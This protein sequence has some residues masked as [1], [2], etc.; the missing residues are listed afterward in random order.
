[1]RVE[2][3]NAERSP[4]L[5]IMSNA[6]RAALDD[7]PLTQSV[8]RQRPSNLPILLVEDEPDQARLVQDVLKE[9]SSLTLLP[10]MPR[11][12][13][14]IAYLS[15]EGRYGDRA[16]YP[17]PF[18]MLL[19]LKMPG[20]GGFGVLRWLQT[21]PEVNGNL[22]TVVLSS[23][24]SSEELELAGGLGAKEYWVKS[25]WMLLALRIRDLSASLR[26]EA[27]W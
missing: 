20:I 2:K 25:D 13:E 7:L 1:M 16:A 26:D 24:Q 18:L 12:E 5:R 10:V 21:H 27:R 4:Q 14:A 6:D 23:L 11:G 17:F 15:G 22:H 9:D 19:D 8:T 3:A